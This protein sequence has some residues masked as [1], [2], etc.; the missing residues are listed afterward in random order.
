MLTFAPR[1]PSLAHIE[2]IVRQD[3]ALF[4][5]IDR[6]CN[7]RRGGRY[8]VQTLGRAKNLY[9]VRETMAAAKTTVELLSRG[10]I[11]DVTGC[12]RPL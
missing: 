7:P 8:E 1:H 4:A 11:D 5:R 2:M 6:G 9:F 12:I 10:L 3:G